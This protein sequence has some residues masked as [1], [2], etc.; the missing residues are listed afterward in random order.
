LVREL[1]GTQLKAFL[2]MGRL[3]LPA[4]TRKISLECGLTR[5]AV[6]A[7]LEQMAGMGL[8]VRHEDPFR[9]KWS[10]GEAARVLLDAV[11]G[12]DA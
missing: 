10:L 5:S 6:K 7:A 8:V 4:T 2:M 11:W 3:P 1:G 9:A 12:A